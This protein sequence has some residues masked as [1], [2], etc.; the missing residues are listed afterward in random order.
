MK[1][2]NV[3]SITFFLE[4]KPCKWATI[5]EL[6]KTNQ[7]YITKWQFNDSTHE[8]SCIQNPKINFQIQRLQ[9]EFRHSNKS[10]VSCLF[11]FLS[12]DM[13]QFISRKLKRLCLI[14]QNVPIMI[15]GET[16]VL[17]S[18]T[19]IGSVWRSTYTR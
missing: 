3:E 2:W 18:V 11:N 10:N 17:K 8:N 4:C 15:N 14:Q 6:L 16:V 5:K 13:S 9:I 7:N 12:I 1:S 19:K